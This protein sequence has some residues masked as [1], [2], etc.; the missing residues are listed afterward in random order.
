MPF[1]RQSVAGVRVDFRHD[2]R[3]V[4]VHAP[5]RRIV[6]HD[7]ALGGDLRRPFLRDGGAR[8]HQADVGVAE[9]EIVERFHFQGRVAVGDFRADAAARGERDHLVGG[10]RPLGQNV[11]HFAP[12]IAGGADDGD[13]E[14]HGLHS[15][16][17]AIRSLGSGQRLRF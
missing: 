4:R 17:L 16:R 3:H 15:S 8:R 6:D 11:H 13:F 2:Q 7:G 12:D 14:T 5:A 9:I 1:L 10:E